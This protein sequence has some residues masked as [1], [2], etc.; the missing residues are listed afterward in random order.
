MI[1][2]QKNKMVTSWT[3]NSYNSSVRLIWKQFCLVDDLIYAQSPLP[4]RSTL[5]YSENSIYPEQC[6]IRMSSSLGSHQRE[7]DNNISQSIVVFHFRGG[8]ANSW[9][10]PVCC[11]IWTYP[12]AWHW[13]HESF[14]VEIMIGRVNIQPRCLDHQPL[15]IYCNG[16]KRQYNCWFNSAPCTRHGALHGN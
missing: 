15:L 12:S 6:N 3:R 8:I 5:A 16:H 1:K 13:L 7:I 4:V 14:L 10:S 11:R 2:H 9:V